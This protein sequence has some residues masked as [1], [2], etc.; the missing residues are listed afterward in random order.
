MAAPTLPT[1]TRRARPADAARIAEIYNQGI[2][3]RVATFETAPR[4]AAD[5]LAW[6]ERPY[7]IV[8]V[9]RA[10][11]VHAFA[12]LSPYRDRACYAGVAEFSVYVA[13]EA[14]G[15]GAGRLAMTALLAAAE[16][17]GFWKLVSRVFVE[18]E[19][20]RKL[21]ARVGFREVGIY[22]KHGRLDG[23]WRDVVIVERLI[24]ANLIS[25]ADK[26]S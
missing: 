14:R 5:I 12:A 6:F 3:D 17:E 10:G 20:S 2:A 11:R 15:Q 26:L 1:G 25:D 24:P 23:V 13:R 7:P 18:N 21:L 4:T 8:V 16:A 19:A 9:E 22:E